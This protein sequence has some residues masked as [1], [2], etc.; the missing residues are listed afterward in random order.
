[1][2]E[3]VK[4]R[5]ERVTEVEEVKVQVMGV[6]KDWGMQEVMTGE[7]FQVVDLEMEVVVEKVRENLVLAEV[8][9]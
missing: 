4:V 6:G 3:A 1:M 7:D 9:G 2:E 5:E 8:A